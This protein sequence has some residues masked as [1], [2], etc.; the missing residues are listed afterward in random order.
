MAKELL[1]LGLPPE[2][3]EALKKPY[4][5]NKGSG[6][7]GLEEDSGKSRGGGRERQSE[8]EEVS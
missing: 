7:G 2:H 4:R 6:R 1:S 5:E 3:C 8:V